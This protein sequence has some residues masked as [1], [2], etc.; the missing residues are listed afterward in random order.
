MTILSIYREDGTVARLKSEL[1]IAAIQRPVVAVVTILTHYVFP[2]RIITHLSPRT[3]HL[4]PRAS[5]LDKSNLRRQS[6]RNR[7]PMSVVRFL[8]VYINNI[9]LLHLA[10]FN[11][12]SV[13]V[14]DAICRKI[15]HFYA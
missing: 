14:S 3:S 11:T 13:K 4:A 15:C 10:P 1:R 5:H 12:S 6:A 7:S 8:I 9:Y 2:V